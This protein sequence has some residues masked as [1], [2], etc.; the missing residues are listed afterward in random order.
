MSFLRKNNT[1]LAN[2]NNAAVSVSTNIYTKVSGPSGAFAINGIAGGR[3]GRIV[4]LQNSTGFTM[5][6]A[7]DSGVD[8]TAANRIYTGTGADVALANNPGF[9]TLIYDSAATRWIVVSTH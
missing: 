3:D 7:N 6:I 2:G 5:T 9:C 1:A 8:P 4:M